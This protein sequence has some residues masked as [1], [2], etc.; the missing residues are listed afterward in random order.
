MCCIP[1][2]KIPD[3]PPENYAGLAGACLRGGW[4]AYKRLCEVR[5]SKEVEE[6]FAGRAAGPNNAAERAIRQAV[7][8]LPGPANRSTR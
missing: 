6:A 5:A 2:R 4:R 3:H 7:L 8:W 1:S